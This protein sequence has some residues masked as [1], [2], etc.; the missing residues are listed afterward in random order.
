MSSFRNR[1]RL[2]DDA[3]VGKAGELRGPKGPQQIQEGTPVVEEK[4][5]LGCLE[6]KQGSIRVALP[7]MPGLDFKAIFL[8][9]TGRCCLIPIHA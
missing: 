9:S 3:K 7:T 6:A 8:S 2:K 4:C 1:R 5:W